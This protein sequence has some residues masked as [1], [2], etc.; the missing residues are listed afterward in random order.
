MGQTSE[1]LD[2]LRDQTVREFLR[3]DNSVTLPDG[4]M[5]VG[6]TVAQ[7]TLSKGGTQFI[8]PG[9]GLTGKQVTTRISLT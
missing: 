3:C 9:E 1:G 8:P 6:D 4:S 2:Q 7:Y 5:W